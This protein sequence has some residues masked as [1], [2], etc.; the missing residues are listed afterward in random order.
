MP[1]QE[2]SAEA[3]ISGQAFGIILKEK[4]PWIQQGKKP[5]HP[6]PP[7]VKPRWLDRGRK[8]TEVTTGEDRERFAF[9][10]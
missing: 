7:D 8:W 9:K 10:I 5:Q 3:F 2:R 4:K 6:L 1:S